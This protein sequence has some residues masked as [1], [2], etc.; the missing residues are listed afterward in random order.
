VGPKG[1]VTIDGPAG[2]GKS[3]VGRLL[4]QS[5][6]FLYLDSGAL[7]R[8]VALKAGSSGLN[9]GDSKALEGFLPGFKPELQAD[10]AGFHLFIDGVEVSAALRTPEVSR[11]ASVVA[12]LPA[13]RGWVKEHL[14]WLARNGGVVA[15]GRDQG[16]AV[17]PEAGFKFYLDAALSTRTRRRQRDW[18]GNA[19]PPSLE[20]TMR[21]LAARDRQDA[22]RDA[23]PL[24]VPEGA[25]VIDT[26]ELT[27]DQVV[28]RCLAEMQTKEH[29]A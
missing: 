21:E 4:A 12:K 8:A 17:F 26:T 18:R 5:L 25:M 9:L 27:V 28:A 23:A 20:E 22:T 29:K 13:V 15:E 6:G 19:D 11:G 16:T 14:R 2:A 10:G 7:Y 1:I 3:T 24:K